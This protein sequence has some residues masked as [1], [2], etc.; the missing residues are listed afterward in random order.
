MPRAQLTRAGDPACVHPAA[1]RHVVS[2]ANLGAAQPRQQRAARSAVKIDRDV[3]P[4]RAKTPADAQ[5]VPELRRP[6]SFPD[7]DHLVDMW[8]VRDDRGGGR[9][10]D[11][12]DVR[13]GESLPDR[14]HGRCGEDDVTDLSEA[15][16]EDLQSSIVASSMSMTGMSSLIGYTRLHVPHLSAV[17]FLTSVTGV[18]QLGHARI[19]SSSG[20]TAMLGIYDTFPLL[21]NNSRDEDRSPR[22]GARHVGIARS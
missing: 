17:P 19:S 8:I 11:I 14:A 9:L 21:W 5:I 10:D 6:S 12:R 4:L 15:D 18:L 1:A 22:R 13:V 2:D 3:V 7:D 16:E 20:S